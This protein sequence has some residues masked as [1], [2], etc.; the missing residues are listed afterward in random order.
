MAIPVR[1]LAV[2]L[3]R[4]TRIELAKLSVAHSVP[5]QRHPQFWS[6][7]VDLNH[8]PS[9]Y[10]SA[11]LPDRAKEGSRLVITWMA[12]GNSALLLFQT[13]PYENVHPRLVP[14]EGIE[15]ST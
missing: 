11:A 14:V 10:E 7:R 12:E 8:R 13:N 5:H 2:N 15:P 3:E 1:N 4:V 9:P 6:L